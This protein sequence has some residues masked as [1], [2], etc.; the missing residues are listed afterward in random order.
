M[1]F[2]FTDEGAESALAP[3]QVSGQLLDMAHTLSTR[4]T[5]PTEAAPVAAADEGAVAATGAAAAVG[6]S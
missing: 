4:Q 2:S 1:G 3:L 6:R 5:K